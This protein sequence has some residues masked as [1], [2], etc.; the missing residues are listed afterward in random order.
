MPSFKYLCTDFM[1]E[2]TKY[3]NYLIFQ[4]TLDSTVNSTTSKYYLGALIWICTKSFYAQ[5]NIK[6]LE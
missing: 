2:H 6:K 4:F 3:V 1:A 5:S